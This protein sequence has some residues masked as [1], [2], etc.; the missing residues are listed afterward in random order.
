[1]RAV[2][3]I[4]A[5]AVASTF[6]AASG[7]AQNTPRIFGLPGSI[8]P[9]PNLNG[10]SGTAK[11]AKKQSPVPDAKSSLINRYVAGATT[12]KDV[13]SLIDVAKVPAR[14]QTSCAA[15]LTELAKTK[16]CT[17]NPLYLLDDGEV[18]QAWVCNGRQVYD[19]FY[20]I[21]GGKLI[22]IWSMD[23]QMPI[24]VAPAPGG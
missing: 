4:L 6:A 10:N 18:R 23:M 11:D 12:G 3:I 9:S 16:G 5:C 19:V 8:C 7:R 21:G 2:I 15:A 24:V 14:T 17:N 22:N 20:T 13:S 1:M